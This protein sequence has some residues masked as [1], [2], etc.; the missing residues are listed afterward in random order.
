[1]TR[2]IYAI[3]IIASA[4]GNS[5]SAHHSYAPY[6]LTRTVEIEGVI[7]EFEWIAPHSLLKVRSDEARLYTAEWRAP[8]GLQRIGI[9]RDTLKE[10]ER[11]VITGNPRRDFDES[12]IL[13]FKSVRRLADGWRWPTSS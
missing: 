1:M 2:V 11:I 12:R 9:E 13:N 5:T 8:V 7:E 10:G 6:D 3:A 4:A